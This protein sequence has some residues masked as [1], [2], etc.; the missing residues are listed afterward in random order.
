MKARFQ[1]LVFLDHSLFTHIWHFPKLIQNITV[2]PL[3]YITAVHEVGKLDEKNFLKQPAAWDLW[4]VTCSLAH[5]M[6]HSESH[7]LDFD[8]TP[9]W[10]TEWH[11]LVNSASS[12]NTRNSSKNLLKSIHVYIF[13]MTK[14]LEGFKKIL[15]F[16]FESIYVIVPVIFQI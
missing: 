12:E 8:V 1:F 10:H 9:F 3:Y 4:F 16:S 2:E 5:Q 11:L 15:E 13:H 7:L 14:K 6:S